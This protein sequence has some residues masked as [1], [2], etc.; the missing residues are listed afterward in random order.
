MATIRSNSARSTG[1][2]AAAM[3]L[4]LASIS[5][6]PVISLDQRDPS[7][8]ADHQHYGNDW[9]HDPILSNASAG[10]RDGFADAFL[11]LG[12]VFL[13]ACLGDLPDQRLQHGRALPDT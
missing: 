11:G 5:V 4:I 12:P 8:N 10:L 2:A 3:A 1:L 13:R 6:S 7:R 9:V